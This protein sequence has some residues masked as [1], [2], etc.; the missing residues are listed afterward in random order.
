LIANILNGEGSSK[1]KQVVKES[2]KTVLSDN[3]TLISISFV[4]LIQTLKD[5]PEVIKLIQN[6]PSA[7]DG[8]Q[9]NDDNN[10]DITNYLEFNRDSILGLAEKNYKNLV[11]VL[12]DGA[13]NNAT[14][15]S[16]NSP[17]FLPQSSDTFPGL[18][19]QSD[20]YRKEEPENYHN[21]EGDIAD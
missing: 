5:D 18:S 13:I 12:T 15:A 16:P 3:K 6:T 9:H 10:N 17:F 7:N 11:E 20:T 21:S 2:V 4:A 14:H 8:K 1:V 19:N